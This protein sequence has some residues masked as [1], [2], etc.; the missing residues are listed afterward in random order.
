MS[1]KKEEYNDGKDRKAVV[2]LV[3]RSAGKILDVGTGDCCCMAQLLAKKSVSLYFAK[4]KRVNHK[5]TATFMARLG[6]VR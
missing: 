2:R 4:V 1:K 5:Y 6:G 3:S